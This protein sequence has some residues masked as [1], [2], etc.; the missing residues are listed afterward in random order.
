MVTLIPQL[1]L[2]CCQL[3]CVACQALKLLNKFSVEELQ[4]IG[5]WAGFFFFLTTKILDFLYTSGNEFPH[6]NLNAWE[7]VGCYC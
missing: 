7:G 6:L 5:D 2:E 3:L 1:P 4:E